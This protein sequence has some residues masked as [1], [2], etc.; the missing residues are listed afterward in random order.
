MALVALASAKGSPGV[1]TLARTVAG[2]WSRPVVLVELDPAGGDLAAREGLPL[3]PGL[4]SLALAARSGLSAELL[5]RHAQRLE[6]GLSLVVAPVHPAQVQAALTVLANELAP[7]AAALAGV[8]VIADCGRLD[9]SSPV[10]GVV[11]QADLVVLVAHP[12]L[13]GIAHLQSA[14]ELVA[15]AEVGVVLVGDG[16]YDAKEVGPALAVPVL[17]VVA[18]DA[19]GARLVGWAGVRGRRSLLSR[20]AVSLASALA[21]RLPVGEEVSR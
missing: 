19:R 5:E 7:V 13:A 10:V 16:D 15:P 20:S 17:G 12:S 4:A 3:E 14:V 1:T 8:D 2:H 18:D 9:R 6:N 21:A 11:R